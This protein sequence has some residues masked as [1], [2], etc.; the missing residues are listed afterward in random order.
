MSTP[1]FERSVFINC[2][3]DEAYA[4]LLGAM[5]FCVTEL[6]YFPRFAPENANNAANRLERIIDLIRTSR[7]GIHDL[8]RSRALKK[9]EYARFNM[10]FELG[11]DYG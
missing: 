1:E 9:G 7:F 11:V 4:P 2:P 10:P 8:S 5:A 3:F 6:G